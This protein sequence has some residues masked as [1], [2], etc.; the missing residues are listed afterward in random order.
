MNMPD[1]TGLDEIRVITNRCPRISSILVS[2][3]MDSEF[4][5][6]VIREGVAVGSVGY[7]AAE[8]GVSVI[9]LETLLWP[10]LNQESGLSHSI[11]AVEFH[12]AWAKSRYNIGAGHE[13][14]EI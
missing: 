13:T 6:L 10:E 9:R 5:G 12:V 14:G 2:G 4:E 7:S 1:M 8:I 11:L 3:Y